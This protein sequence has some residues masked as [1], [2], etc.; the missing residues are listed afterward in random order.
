MLLKGVSV[1]KLKKMLPLGCFLGRITKQILVYGK[2]FNVVT[3]VEDT[4]LEK[5][6]S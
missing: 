5:K 2:N 4:Y 3:Y 6:F 1:G